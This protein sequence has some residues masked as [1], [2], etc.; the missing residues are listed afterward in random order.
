MLF[1]GDD[2][3]ENHHDVELVDEAGRLLARRRPP[4]GV[5]GM[6]GLHALIAQH[7]PED[8]EATDVVIG[9]EHGCRDRYGNGS[10]PVGDGVDR[11]RLPGVCDQP[12]AGGAVPRTPFDLG[13]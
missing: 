5:E 11:R 10:G 9:M 7:L 6:A 8:G 2:R 12:D 13:C 3:A 4:E 1:V